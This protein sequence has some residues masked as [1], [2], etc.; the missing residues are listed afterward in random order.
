MKLGRANGADQIEDPNGTDK[1]IC[2][3]IGKDNGD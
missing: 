1:K 2:S 3:A